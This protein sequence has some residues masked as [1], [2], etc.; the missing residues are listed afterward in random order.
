MIGG[1][2]GVHGRI[3][4]VADTPTGGAVYVDYARPA[5]RACPSGAP[6]PCRRQSWW[7]CSA[8]AAIGTR[9]SGRRW[10]NRGAPR[11]PRDRDRRQSAYRGPGD[12]IRREVLAGARTAEEIGDRAAAI[13]VAMRD[14]GRGDLLVIAGKGHETYQIIGETKHPFD[15]SEIARRVADDRR[16]ARHERALD[17]GRY[18]LQPPGRGWR[19]SRR[20]ACRS[21]AATSPRRSLR[22]AGAAEFRRLMTTSPSPRRWRPGAAAAVVDRVP[23]GLRPMRRWSLPATPLAALEALGQTARHR[24]AIEGEILLLSPA[25]SADSAP[26]R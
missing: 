9:A 1:I 13:R 19:S 14:L 4:H 11:R 16:K 26:R 20:P 5:A 22:G 2:S 8:A 10:R 3:E 15:D 23:N 17:I 25:V 7:S 24:R 6:A 21:T 18:R 12:A